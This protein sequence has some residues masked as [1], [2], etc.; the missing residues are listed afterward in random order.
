MQWQR[1]LVFSFTLLLARPVAARADFVTLDF[2]GA[3]ATW[4]TAID[5][6]NVI[7][8]YWTPSSSGSHG[9]LYNGSSFT[10]IDVPGFT[11]VDLRGIS[12]SN[13]VGTSFDGGGG[14]QPFLY[15][16]STVT[17]ISPPGALSTTVFGV[18]GNTVLGDFWNN[19]GVHPFLQNGSTPT[20]LSLLEGA[21]A[22]AYGIS[23]TTVVGWQPAIGQGVIYDGTTLTAVNVPGALWTALFASSGNLVL[24]SSNLGAFVYDGSTFTMIDPPPDASL[25]SVKGI[26]GNTVVGTYTDSDGQYHGFVE[27]LDEPIAFGSGPADSPEPASVVLLA[28]GALGLGGYAGW[29]RRSQ[30]LV[31]R[32]GVASGSAGAP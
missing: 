15:N 19:F 29:R 5:G 10:T 27:T 9:F 23:G 14:E 28:G 17:P 13:I 7:G 8:D 25:F 32:I 21:Q 11:H 16:G 2:P 24:G 31:Q 26:S 22:V 30:L 12:G 6:N 18:S 4:A 1:C 20:V 3:S